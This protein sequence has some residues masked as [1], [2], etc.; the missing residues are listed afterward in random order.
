MENF[1]FIKKAMILECYY[2]EKKIYND[3][4]KKITENFVVFFFKKIKINF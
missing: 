4:N 2:I 3:K 1:S